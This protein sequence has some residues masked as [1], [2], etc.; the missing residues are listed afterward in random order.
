[1]IKETSS[2]YFAILIKR[3]LKR[4]KKKTRKNF[5]A[6]SHILITIQNY[7]SVTARRK[8]SRRY[9]KRNAIL[10][11]AARRYQHKISIPNSERPTQSAENVAIET[12]SLMENL[13]P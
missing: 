11:P 6:L 4:K 9:P 8:R 1:M 3:N 7:Y 13:D 2:I 5:N 10:K 12:K